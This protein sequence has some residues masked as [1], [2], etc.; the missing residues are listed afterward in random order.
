MANNSQSASKV[1]FLARSLVELALAG[2]LVVAGLYWWF[3]PKGF[4]L[5]HS[6]FWLNSVLPPAVAIAACFGLAGMLRCRRFVSAVTATSMGAGWSAVSIASLLLFPE[7]LHKIW[8]L[9]IAAL[10]FALLV[11]CLVP[12]DER[13]VPR[14]ALPLILFSATLGLLVVLTERP[15]T[16]T[17]V[18]SGRA[19]APDPDTEM[20]VPQL[21]VEIGEDC[22]FYPG[23]GE[24]ALKR[25]GMTIRCTPLLSFERISPDGF[26]SLL[27]P[28]S[29]TR[30]RVLTAFGDTSTQTLLYSDDSTIVIPN[31]SESQQV[32]LTASS[33]VPRETFTHLNSYSVLEISGHKHL[34]L[35]F[36]PCSQTEVD[37]LPAD[38]PSGRPA[39]FA[40]LSESGMFSVVEATSGEKGPFRELASGKMRRGDPLS[41]NILNQGKC[42]AKVTFKDWSAQLSTAVS[43]TAGWGVPVNAIEFQRIADSPTAPAAIWITLAATSVGRGWQSVGHRAGVYSNRIEL[44]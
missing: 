3:S 18:P 44:Q 40:F 4:A 43:P 34:S 41:I 5:E 13:L 31:R 27:A 37:V 16:P 35:C 14:T 24:V 21:P 25:S 22:W 26:W 28:A 38:Y 15:A 23:P 17:T 19:A 6:R 32:E 11:T 10:G 39:R 30:R 20:D 8:I 12:R 36:S 7:S 29:S 9:G 2:H 33:H 1:G 42:V